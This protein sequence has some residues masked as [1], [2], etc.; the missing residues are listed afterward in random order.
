MAL[1]LGTTLCSSRATRIAQIPNANPA[2][3]VSH[4]QNIYS[5]NRTGSDIPRTELEATFQEQNWKRHSKNRIGS[6]ILET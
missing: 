4:K 6:D 1:N 5:K 3:D 2:C